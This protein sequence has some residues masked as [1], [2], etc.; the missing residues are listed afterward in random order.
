MSSKTFEEAWAAKEREGYRYGED[1]LELV[2]LGW[3]IRD[4]CEGEPRADR[5]T[6]HETWMN[7][8]REISKRSYDKRLKVGAIIVTEDNTQMLA[9]GFN[10][11]Y[12][13]GPNQA[14]S[15]EPGQSGLIH[16]EVNALIKCDFHHPRRKH[17][18]VTTSPCVACAKLIINA[19]IADVVY[20]RI[21]RDPSGVELLRTAGVKVR[22]LDEA[23][24]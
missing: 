23:L 11:N 21:Y 18:Y 3:Q 4:G 1:A 24:G 16:A 5:P 6:W 13:G 7:V 8:A 22:S 10:G 19:D 9:V 15:Q 14:D 2:R 12:R 20:D 17:M